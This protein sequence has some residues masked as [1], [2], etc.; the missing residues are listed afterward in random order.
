MLNPRPRSY[1][2]KKQPPPLSQK[3]GAVRMRRWRL[4]QWS[5]AIALPSRD[6]MPDMVQRLYE[7]EWLDHNKTSDP[8]AISDAIFSLTEEALKAGAKKPRRECGQKLIPWR[9]GAQFIG[10]L[11]RFRWLSPYQD[12]QRSEHVRSAII[13]AADAAMDRGLCGPLRRR[14]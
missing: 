13:G 4:R 2:R 6:V 5:H 3:P 12:G 10:E 9:I 8:K 14:P 7:L 11:V 1:V